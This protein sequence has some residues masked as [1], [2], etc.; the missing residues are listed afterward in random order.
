MNNDV[1]YI[2]FTDGSCR[3]GTHDPNRKYSAYGVVLLNVKTRKYTAFGDELGSRTIGYAEL[4]AIYK[5][6]KR[7]CK[8]VPKKQKTKIL[9][10]SDNKNC[11]DAFRLWIPYCW[12]TS[13]WYNW[14]GSKKTK[15]K[16]QNLYRKILEL[17]KKH[18]W[19]HPH[20]AHINS[21]LEK[22]DLGAIRA[23]L[24]KV[25][26]HVDRPTSNMIRVMNQKA[27]TIASDIS[28]KLR[29]IDEE[30][31]PFYQLHYITDAIFDYDDND[32]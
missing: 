32:E 9:I 4:Y 7:L 30:H 21:H 8:I 31:G 5:G 29:T 23:K 26:V 10:V 28:M 15:V 16:N 2:V 22:A 27:D 6:V 14:K 3:A 25:N 12:D 18:P 19:I 11:I 24:Q 1:D 13:D 20:Y 17:F